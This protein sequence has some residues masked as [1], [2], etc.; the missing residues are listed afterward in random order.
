MT[1]LW[2]CC[3]PED[4][5]ALIQYQFTHYKENIIPGLV[6]IE[7]NPVMVS[8]KIEEPEEIDKLMRQAPHTIHE[9][10]ADD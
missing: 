1:E 3:K 10:G 5:A 9:E 6:S 4:L 7:D 2:K 8:G